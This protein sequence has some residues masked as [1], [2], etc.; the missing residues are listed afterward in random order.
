ME[1]RVK[2]PTFKPFQRMIRLMMRKTVLLFSLCLS[3]AVLNSALSADHW[4]Q[5]QGPT[6]NSHSTS[7]NLPLNWSET[8]NIKWEDTDSRQGLVVSG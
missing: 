8:E 1:S 7:K 4:Y 3:L 6:G 2:L 5:F